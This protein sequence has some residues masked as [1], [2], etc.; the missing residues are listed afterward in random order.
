MTWHVE[1]E[2]SNRRCDMVCLWYNNN[3][4]SYKGMRQKLNLSSSQC[5]AP[6][7]LNERLKPVTFLLFLDASEFRSNICLK[8]FI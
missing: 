7:L 6:G 3:F 4:I 8:V 5:F 2:L 1:H